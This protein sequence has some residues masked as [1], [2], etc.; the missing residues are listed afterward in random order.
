MVKPL[1][2]A[3]VY[4]V[5][6]SVITG[7]VYP[8]VVTLIAQLVWPHQA[9]GSLIVQNN[10]IVGSELIGQEFTKPEYFWSRLSATGTLPYNAAASGGS[11][12]G[13]LH[14]ELQKALAKRLEQLQSAQASD[15][16]VPIDLVTSSASGLDPHISPA[17]AYFQAV[18][19]ARARGLS[20]AKMQDLIMQ[21]TEPRQWGFLGEARVNVLKLN[22]ALDQLPRQR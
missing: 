12:Y 17:S 18:R 6:L 3:C 13:P 16:K 1:R 2:I 11:N 20:D 15:T 5:L 14:A 4:F 22:L 8:G 7:V 9:N 19:V 10:Q 21:H